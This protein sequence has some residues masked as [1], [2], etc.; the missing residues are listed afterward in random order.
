[1]RGQRWAGII[2]AATFTFSTGA[3]ATVEKG[4][5]TE[6]TPAKTED[7]VR[8]AV[9]TIPPRQAVVKWGKKNLGAI[10][11]PKPLIVVRPR[12]SGPLDLVIRMTGYLPVHTRAGTFSDSRLVVKLTPIEEK[13]TLFGYREELPPEELPAPAPDPSAPSQ[14]K[15]APPQAT[16]AP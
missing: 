6:T 9:Q 14:A 16:T 5:A 15:P 12:D 7:N 3:R 4:K 13:K 10:P 2:L 11:V 8:I 1:M